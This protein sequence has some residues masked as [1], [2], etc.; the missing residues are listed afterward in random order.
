MSSE[1][2]LFDD[3]IGFLPV[4]SPPLVNSD[5]QGRAILLTPPTT[6]ESAHG[7]AIPHLVV[8]FS[9]LVASIG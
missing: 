5:Y 7:P 9:D 6:A 1:V 8:C 2:T 4:K 3:Q